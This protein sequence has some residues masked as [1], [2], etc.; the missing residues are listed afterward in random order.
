MRR[1]APSQ[2]AARKPPVVGSCVIGQRTTLV[3]WSGSP[4]GRGAPWGLPPFNLN[5]NVRDMNRLVDAIGSYLDAFFQPGSIVVTIHD[6]HRALDPL[7]SL[8]EIS[9]AASRALHTRPHWLRCG[10]MLIDRRTLR[11]RVLAQG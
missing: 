1:S 10:P 2:P 3:L 7:V 8:D 5:S 6:L 4:S 11:D 9:Y